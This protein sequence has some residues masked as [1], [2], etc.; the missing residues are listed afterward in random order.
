MG[1]LSSVTSSRAKLRVG[2]IGC[3][4]IFRLSHLLAVRI[5]ERAPAPQCVAF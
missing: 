5:G 3:G 2:L 4:G 1:L